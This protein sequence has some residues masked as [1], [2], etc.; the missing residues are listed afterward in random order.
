MPSILDML[1]THLDENALRQISSSV[2]ADSGVTSKGIAAAIPVL[3]GALAHN[4]NQG[5]GAQQ[6]NDALAKDHDGSVLNDVAGALRGGQTAD[7]NAI[8]GHVLGDR[9]DVAEQAVARASGLDVS[10]A[11]PLLAMLA[12]V[13]MGALGRARQQGGLDAQGLAGMLGGEQEALG[14]AAPGVMGVVSRL[15]DRDHDGSA[16]DDVGAMLG[17]LFGKR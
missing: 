4:A 17:G 14:A 13:V 16:L 3:L 15:L 7:G 6:L 5:D 2:G 12:P 10:K 1:S 11:G 8:L 9:R